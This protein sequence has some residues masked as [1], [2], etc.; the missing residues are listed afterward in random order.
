MRLGALVNWLF[1]VYAKDKPERERRNLLEPLGGGK[2]GLADF[3]LRRYLEGRGQGRLNPDFFVRFRPSQQFTFI[4]GLRIQ[5]AS[6]AKPPISKR[7]SSGEVS[8][9]RVRSCSRRELRSV[10][11]RN[12]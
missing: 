8:C 4:E 7:F 9:E 12:T 2:I 11:F 6:F 1:G 3:Q 10:G 5:P